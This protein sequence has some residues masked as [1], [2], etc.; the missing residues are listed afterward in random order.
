MGFEIFIKF[1]EGTVDNS[2]IMGFVWIRI[3]E[4]AFTKTTSTLQRC[5]FIKVKLTAIRNPSTGACVAVLAWACI[6]NLGEGLHST[7]AV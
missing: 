3:R 2:V 5:H 7:S 6:V 1:L 4:F